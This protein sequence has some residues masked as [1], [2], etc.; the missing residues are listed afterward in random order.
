MNLN[1]QSAALK[2]VGQESGI[3]NRQERFLTSAQS[4]DGPEGVRAGKPE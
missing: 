3:K 4:A 1:A 2:G